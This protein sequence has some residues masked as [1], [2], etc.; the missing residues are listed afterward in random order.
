[1]AIL[2]EE[3]DFD[4]RQE[5]QEL[6]VTIKAVQESLRDTLEV[7]KWLKMEYANLKQEY[8]RVTNT[9]VTNASLSQRRDELYGEMLG[10]SKAINRL[11]HIVNKLPN[12]PQRGQIYGK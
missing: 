12:P 9:R 10:L 8:N 11:E 2:D 4:S 7:L 3:K 1:M 5:L 6:A